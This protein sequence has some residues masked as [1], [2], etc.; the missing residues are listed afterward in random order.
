MRQPWLRRDVVTTLLGVASTFPPQAGPPQLNWLLAAPAEA[1]AAAP[2]M[3]SPGKL[4]VYALK[5]AALDPRSFRGLIL[6]NGMRVLLVQDPTATTGAASMNV[7]V[8]SL[9][10]QPNLRPHKPSFANSRV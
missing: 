6:A 10:D 1:A 5:G 2:G 9:S 4:A 8:G 3:L 7:Q